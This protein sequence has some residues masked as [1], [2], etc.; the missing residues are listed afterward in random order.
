MGSRM[1]TWNQLPYKQSRTAPHHTPTYLAHGRE[2]LPDLGPQR[3]RAAADEEVR[4]QPQGPHLL[5]NLCVLGVLVCV[6]L[7]IDVLRARID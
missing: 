5:I 2:F 7:F 6:C 4:G 1:H 3:V